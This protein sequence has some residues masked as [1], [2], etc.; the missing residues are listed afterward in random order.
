MPA[1][2]LIH[3]GRIAVFGW[4]PTQPLPR[5]I[6]QVDPVPVVAPRLP[7]AL[8]CGRL[9]VQGRI[10]THPGDQRQVQ[11]PGHL[12][13]GMVTEMTVQRQR[14]ASPRRDGTITQRTEEPVYSEGLLAR[15][16]HDGLVANEQGDARP[17]IDQEPKETPGERQPVDRRRKETRDAAIAAA[18]FG[19]ATD[20]FVGEASRPGQNRLGDARQ[21]PP[22]RL[23]QSRLQTQQKG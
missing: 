11:L 6:R 19:P 3:L 22:G 4:A 5:Q 15:F 2:P 18:R 1:A 7:L 14:E 16:A 21:W 12:T 17:V 8:G 20:A 13:G 9:G 23:G 10:G